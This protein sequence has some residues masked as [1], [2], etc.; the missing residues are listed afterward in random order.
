[1]SERRRFD[2]HR[3]DNFAEELGLEPMPEAQPL[4]APPPRSREDPEM[5]RP[6]AK[7]S[8]T[9]PE[10]QARRAADASERGRG[11]RRRSAPPEQP[12]ERPVTLSGEEETNAPPG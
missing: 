5:S 3:W 9:L 11:R 10:E 7:E 4:P 1:M 8:P 12:A 6:A 2:P